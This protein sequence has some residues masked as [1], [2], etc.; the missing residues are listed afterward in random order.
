MPRNAPEMSSGEC[1]S[2][3]R[4]EH[5]TLQRFRRSWRSRSHLPIFDWDTDSPV[6]FLTSSLDP[7]PTFFGLCGCW[8]QL[9]IRTHYG[10]LLRRL[11]QTSRDFCEGLVAQM[12]KTPH[13]LVRASLKIIKEF[14]SPGCWPGSGAVLRSY[15]AAPVERTPI[16]E[17][18]RTSARS[19]EDEGIQTENELANE[20]RSFAGTQLY[21]GGTLQW[22]GSRK[23]TKTNTGRAA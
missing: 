10:T 6:Y 8:S 21:W 18:M 22:S 17:S 7:V 19:G 11:W 3:F 15:S 5:W 20:R 16:I 1:Q 13:R 14:Y 9:G 4:E 12:V 2:V 23:R